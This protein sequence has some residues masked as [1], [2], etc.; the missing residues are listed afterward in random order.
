MLG[1]PRLAR[2]DLIQIKGTITEALA[3]GNYRVKGDNGMEFIAKI[4]G[5]MRRYHIR[6]IPGDRVTIAVSPY[7]PTH[8]LIVFRGGCGRRGHLSAARDRLELGEPGGDR[9]VRGHAP[10][11]ARRER[12]AGADLRGVGHAVALEL[13]REEP[14]EEDVEPA[15]NRG[16]I[17]APLE[18]R[19]RHAGEAPRTEAEAQEVVEEEVVQLVGTDE[20]L[21]V[22]ADLARRR[23]AT[24]LGAD[25]HRQHVAQR[26]SHRGLAGEYPLGGPADELDHERLRHARVHAV[27]RDVVPAVGGVAERQLREVAG[28]EVDGAE[29]AGDRE[30]HELPRPRL[31]VLEGEVLDRWIV[32]DASKDPVGDRADVDL[33][34]PRAESAHEG[35]G[36]AVRAL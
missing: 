36:D 21:G 31:H 27:V 35:G 3:G 7:D 11:A 15:A 32:P 17:I 34:E 13:A 10:V 28:A 29:P 26:V 19:E 12:P 1:R 14:A 24:E 23:R 20:R 25:R 5:R 16:E 8:G 6:V 9:G 4:G 22:L 33:L 18:G 30:Q 2:D